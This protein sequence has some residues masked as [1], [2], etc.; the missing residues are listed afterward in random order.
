MIDLDPHLLL[1]VMRFKSKKEL[2]NG[3]LFYAAFMI[4]SICILE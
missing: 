3:L 4:Q 2:K 1:V